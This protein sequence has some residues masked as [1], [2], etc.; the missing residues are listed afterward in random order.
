ME[1]ELLNDKTLNGPHGSYSGN[2]FNLPCRTV[3]MDYS[4][5]MCVSQL[6]GCSPAAEAGRPVLSLQFQLDSACMTEGMCKQ[7]LAN[8]LQE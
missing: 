4:P 6:K 1:L 5:F 7:P 8:F 2:R 3:Y